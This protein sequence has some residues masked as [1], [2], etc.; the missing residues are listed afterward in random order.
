MTIRGKGNEMSLMVNWLLDMKTAIRTNKCLRLHAPKVYEC[1]QQPP[2]ASLLIA[3]H[4]RQVISSH[5]QE[6]NCDISN[7]QFVL[8]AGFY[9]K[10]K[11][12]LI[13]FTSYS[14]C[15]H[16]L[17]MHR[18]DIISNISQHFL[19]QCDVFLIIRA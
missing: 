13:L 1:P 15:F 7:K 17:Y 16:V 11:V 2:R 12:L 10:V 3:A 14:N 18:C 6:T 8:V 9:G 5:L 19:P 4:W